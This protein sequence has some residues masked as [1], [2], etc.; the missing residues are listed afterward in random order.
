MGSKRFRDSEAIEQFRLD[1]H[2]GESLMYQLNS[3]FLEETI[4]YMRDW[5]RK[6]LLDYIL[7][8]EYEKARLLTI[9]N[10]LYRT[11]KMSHTVPTEMVMSWAKILGRM[12]LKFQIWRKDNGI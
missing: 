10:G 4:N 2:H 3:L 6:P 9:V 7:D 5:A 8:I 11:R 12:E 1:L